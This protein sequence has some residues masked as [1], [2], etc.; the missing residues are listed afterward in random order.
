V[1]EEKKEIEGKGRGEVRVRGGGGDRGEEKR[2]ERGGR[3]GEGGEMDG[4]VG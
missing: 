2:G 1:G 4:G 3:G